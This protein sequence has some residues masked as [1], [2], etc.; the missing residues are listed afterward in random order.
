MI[1]HSLI[2]PTF[3]CFVLVC[4]AAT[5][6]GQEV[7]EGIAAVVNTE[8]I[9]FSQLRDWVSHKELQAHQTFKGQE[10]VDRIKAIRAQ[11]VEEL[12]D[13][14][15]ILQDFKTKGGV[16]PNAQVEAQIAAIIRDRFK[17]DVKAFLQDLAAKGS[18]LDRFR[19]S[20]RDSIIVDDACK[21]A[22]EGATSP[23]EADLIKQTLLNRLQNKAYIKIY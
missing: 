7:L 1:C 23:S 11:G 10:L 6:R 4:L 12:I 13:R 3:L 9:N 15:L 8:P 14:A 17:G 5:A 16:P 2:F 21:N 22:I 18:S 19:D 20:I